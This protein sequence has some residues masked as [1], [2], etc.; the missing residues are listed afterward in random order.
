MRATLLGLLEVRA[1][2]NAT[3]LLPKTYLEGS[4]FLEE[5][6]FEMKYPSSHAVKS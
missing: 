5:F 1:L 2:T 4:S 3:A 6:A